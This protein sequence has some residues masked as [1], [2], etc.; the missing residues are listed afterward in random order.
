MSEIWYSHNEEYF[1]YQDLEEAFYDLHSDGDIPVSNNG[2]GIATVYQ[3][4]SVPYKAEDIVNSECLAESAIESI[5]EETCS[6]Y[7][8]FEPSKKEETEL[9]NLIHGAIAN[10]QVA[11]PFRI[12][13]VKEVK[14]LFRQDKEGEILWQED[15]TDAP[16]RYERWEQIREAKLEEQRQWDEENEED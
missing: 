13:N 4:E 14:I 3:G 10:W 5:C 15:I 2:Y 1:S 8:E 9:K 7:Y 11:M 12:I 6:D 16:A